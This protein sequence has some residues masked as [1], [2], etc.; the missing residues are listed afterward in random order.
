MLPRYIIVGDTGD[1]RRR[2]PL[3]LSVYTADI[4][5]IAFGRDPRHFLAGR[6]LGGWVG[7]VLVINPP[8][9]TPSRILLFWR[10][11]EGQK[12]EVVGAACLGVA[13]TFVRA[14]L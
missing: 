14:P 7:G 8:R 9:G 5:R 2:R 12:D 3:P 1:C 13:S 11:K 10:S 4:R 6:R